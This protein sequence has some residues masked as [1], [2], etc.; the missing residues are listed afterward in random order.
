[1]G[2]NVTLGLKEIGWE[3]LDQAYLAQGDKR[4]KLA[5]MV[6]NFRAS[7]NAGNSQKGL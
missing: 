7:Q 1:M 3:N 2:D 5:K 6:T 4:R